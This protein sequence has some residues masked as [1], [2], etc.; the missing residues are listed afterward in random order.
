M[1]MATCQGDTVSSFF[2]TQHFV[3]L[4][5]FICVYLC[6]SRLLLCI[7]LNDGLQEVVC[8]SLKMFLL[9]R[10]SF[11]RFW[12]TITDPLRCGLRKSFE[13]WPFCE[14]T[15]APYPE[16][17]WAGAIF[18]MKSP[19]LIY[20]D[21]RLIYINM[22]IIYKLMFSLMFRDVKCSVY[23]KHFWNIV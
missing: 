21:Y 18:Y 14:G 3:C 12:T 22:Y 15:A 4:I 23:C 6:L 16:H 1:T 5:M 19:E 20:T 17:A 9:E 8:H 7:S 13:P 2:H 11:L 10:R